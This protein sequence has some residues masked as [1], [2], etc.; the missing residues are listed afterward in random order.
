[1]EDVEHTGEPLV[2]CNES[3][4]DVKDT[5]AAVTVRRK[6]AAV[7]EASREEGR[8]WGGCGRDGKEAAREHGRWGTEWL[9]PEG[10]PRETR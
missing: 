5:A 8:G 1:M 7:V 6:A 3:S 10:G 4:K 2:L 9:G